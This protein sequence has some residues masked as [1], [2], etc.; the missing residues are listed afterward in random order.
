[1]DRP[2]PDTSCA[3]GTA[4]NRASFDAHALT[5]GS[6]SRPMVTQQRPSAGYM[7]GDSGATPQTRFARTRV[8]AAA[9]AC[10]CGSSDVT[11]PTGTTN[12]T[13][14]VPARTSFTVGIAGG[15]GS[16]TYTVGDTVYTFGA[17]TATTNAL[18]G[19]TGD[20]VTSA[21]S[22]WSGRF[23][24]PARD[25]AL[26]VT[27]QAVNAPLS[28]G[29]FVGS[30]ARQKT[31]RYYIPP[32]PRGL[33]LVF[34]GTGGS[35]RV[36]EKGE[37]FAIALEA[38]AAGYGVLAY[39]AEESV[40]GDLDGNGKARW[41]VA[42]TLTNTDFANLDALVVRLRA[43]GL[44][45]ASLPLY[46]F[47]MSNGSSMVIAL[48]ALASQTDLATRFPN[49]RFRAVAGYCAPGSATAVAIT[50][51]PS[52]WYVCRNDNNDEVGADGVARQQQNSTTLQLRGIST[53]LAFNEAAPLYDERFTRAGSIDVATSRALVV[54]LKT[55][56]YLDS[57]RFLNQTPDVISA[58]ILRLGAA[59]FPVLSALTATQRA[60]V[61]DALRETYADHQLFSDQARRMLAFFAR[62]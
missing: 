48:G 32:N 26:T 56:G 39:E 54:E 43:T 17:Y 5:N 3:E 21:L 27:P 57:R 40:A 15:F 51:T 44:I 38:V 30:T 10:A 20:A 8:V 52:A 16:G 36:I 62:F 46:A 7:R 22:E 55:R 1:M 18:G 31:L 42:L 2:P 47:G 37:G 19:W 6:D 4:R 49:L 35:S 24:M 61:S 59:G 50:R 58:D 45:S 34:H 25:V 9:L 11:A 60:D 23:V 41:D 29:A 12:G 53:D 14:V 28:I 33:L 13:P